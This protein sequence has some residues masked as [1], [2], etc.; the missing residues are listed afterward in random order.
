VRAN[1]HQNLASSVDLGG[2][3]PF[4]QS[5]SPAMTDS[6]TNTVDAAVPVET[7]AN[8]SPA[9]MKPISMDTPE[10]E[11]RESLASLTKREARLF[12]ADITC[13]L[14]EQDDMSCLACPLNESENDAE[15]K[16]ALCRIGMTQEVTCAHL[17][18]QRA[19]GV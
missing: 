7:M 13:E 19:V 18:A 16:Q 14:K 10:A 3:D 12:S 17:L 11:L 8:R 4:E 6:A 5:F 15:P 9:W 1:W 2:I